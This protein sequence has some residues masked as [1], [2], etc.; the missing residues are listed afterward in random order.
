MKTIKG[1]AK[2]LLAAALSLLILVGLLPVSAFAAGSSVTVTFAY[3]YQS[4]GSQI[5]YQDS[6]VG[7][8]STNGGAGRSAV[9]IYANGEEAYCIEPGAP[10]QTGAVLTENTSEAWNNLGTAKKE[11]IKRALAF[12]KPGNEGGLTGS[13]DAKHL[14]TQMIVWEFV[15]GYRD[16]SSY[17]LLDD[18]VYE[19][20]CKNGA[21]AEVAAN[22]NAIIYAI[23]NW[24]TTPSFANGKTYEMSYQNGKYVVSLTDSN[25]VLSSYSVTSSDS[26][27]KISRTGN[28]ITLT[29]DS[30]LAAEPTITVQKSSNISAS[31]VLVSYGSPTLQDI[32]VGMTRI[33]GISANFKV[34]TPGGTL[35]LVKTSE[36]GIVEGV[37]FTITGNGCNKVVTTEK[38]GTVSVEGLLPGTYAVSETSA[39][40]YE[41]Q[42]AKNVTITSGETTTVTFNNTLKRGSLSV[43]K[44]AEDGFTEGMKFHLY[45]TSASG[46]AVDLYST[47]DSLGVATFNNVLIAGANG[48]T[49]E[50]VDTENRYVIPDDQNVTVVWNEV[51]EATVNN[52]LKKFDVTVVKSDAETG[53]AQGDATLAGAVYGIYRDGTLVKEYITDS[54]GSFTTDYYECGDTWTIKEITP[55]EGYLL[56]ETEYH[57]GAEPENYE[58]ELNHV[59]AM[60]AYEQVIKGNISIIKHSDDGSTQIETPEVGAA[61][62]VYLASA[63][64]YENAKESERDSLICDENG[65]AQTKELPYGL[66]TVRQTAG[67]PDTEFMKDFTAF[68]SENSKTYR[69][70]IN[71]APYTA[72]IRVVKAD[73]ETGNS[74]PLTG[75]GFEIYDGNG[76]KITM[77]YTYPTLTTIDTFYVSEDG[78]LIT[79]QK[80]SAGNYQLVEVQAPYGY[81]L[82]STPIDFTVTSSE[83]EDVEG[84]SVITVT[85]YDMAQKGKISITK[86]G[87][88]FASVNVTGE[89]GVVDKEGTWGIVNPIYSAVYEVQ[90][91]QG[92]TY[93]V[94]ADENIYTGD[95][96]L[97]AEVGTVVAELTTDKNGI[98]ETG[99][100]YLGKYRIRETNAPEGFTLNPEEQLIALTYAGQE[101]SVTSAATS[102]INDRQKLQLSAE[103]AMEQNETYGIGMNGEITAVS[104]GLYAK[105][106]IVA[107]DGSVIPADGLLEIAFADEEGNVSFKSDLP[108]GSYYVRELTT[109]PH[110]CLDESVY[111]VEFSYS[112]HETDIQVV[113]LT[114]SAIENRIK[115]G[116][117]EGYKFNDEVADGA[118]YGLSGA[119]FGI[120]AEGSMELD[121]DHALT[122]VTS[123]ENGYFAFENVPYGDYLVVELNAPIGYALSD[124][125]HFVSVI[126]A[127]QVIGLKVIN[128][129]ITGSM[130]LT[131]VDKDYPDNHLTGA[132]FS[133]YKDTSGDGAPN[134]ED[135]L[136]GTM[137]E[138]ENGVYRMDGL[139]SG[140][141][142]VKETKAPEGFLM[143]ENSYSFS[144]TEDGEVVV[145]ENEAGVGFAD[146]V[147][148][149]QI[150]ISKTDKATGAKLVGAGFRVLDKNGKTV[151]EGK[152]GDDGTISFQLRYGEYTVA[153]YEAPEGF[154]L[155]DTPYSFTVRENGQMLSVDMSN[156]K[157][158]GTLEISKVDAN[159][160]KLLPDAGFRIYASDEKTVVKEGRTDKNGVCR[161]TLE[162]G[163]YYYQEFD[164]PDG[165]RI[166]DTKYA[167]AITEDGK[168]VSVVIT[169]Q[170]EEKG[171]N[172]EPTSSPTHTPTSTSTKTSSKDGPKTG[173]D[174]NIGKWAAIAALALAAAGIGGYCLYS[175]GKQDDKK[176]KKK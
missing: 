148:M 129:P 105:N 84:L 94:I 86:S 118:E 36:D 159:T 92:A 2:S 63:G 89:E 71:N 143:D 109:D 16:A 21:N 77:S 144:I 124:A 62:E 173:D 168:V 142:I 37:E 3:L 158:S 56:D 58:I 126:Y 151:A 17:A 132:E 34:S 108:F 19:A 23:Q 175:T 9:Q 44:T 161:F 1:K 135:V 153:E 110:Y 27:V 133:V 28:T 139:R 100:L 22:Y 59:P 8:H 33:G 140:L 176:K 123:N 49:L 12:G 117:I 167:F 76:D 170:K 149:G 152:T 169:N 38:N 52:V 50:E 73:A 156:T 162:F 81:V 104:F 99:E 40:Y 111:D 72:Y 78:Y 155:D 83:N 102:Y 134:G 31:A 164:A 25:G 80:L 39:S 47:T 82:D 74:I 114:G 14:A 41:P 5:M 98:A 171:E 4:D 150:T 163:K 57:V 131:K 138:Y 30:Y 141:Y 113:E 65:F 42:Q 87:E 79:P 61:F 29:C 125:R 120:F 90:N 24:D 166:D 93:Q 96:T 112:G 85:A 66:Y 97:R 6:F 10:L 48:Y 54:A 157:I 130:E 18:C 103:K 174:A 67:N 91:L 160:E 146:Q 7:T 64:S 60:T 68:I 32:V 88:V 122:T 46:S 154:V 145:V 20:F 127:E 26:K 15:C 165:Y 43:S 128:Y 101:V 172:T 45:G 75:A 95:G 11:S 69:Y 119:V 121:A 55:S 106:E 147:I 107:A 53:A 13:G 35:N 116:R 115:Y 136:I 70:L 137:T 51:A